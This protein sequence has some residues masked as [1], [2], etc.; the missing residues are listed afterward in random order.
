M[1]LKFSSSISLTDFKDDSLLRN[2]EHDPRYSAFLQKMKTP[3]GLDK[4]KIVE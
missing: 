2:I 3:A 1:L 4:L